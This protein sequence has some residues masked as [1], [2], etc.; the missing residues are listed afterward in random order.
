MASRPNVTSWNLKAGDCVKA[1]WG[2]RR[3]EASEGRSLTRSDNPHSKSAFA[4]RVAWIATVLTLG[5]ISGPLGAGVLVNFRHGRPFLGSMYA[6]LLAAWLA[7]LPIFAA[8][9][10]T[11]A[12]AR[13]L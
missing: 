10:L 7:F 9:H 6:F 13:L 11:Y 4:G 2:S 5:P 3:G 1:I 12:L 8:H